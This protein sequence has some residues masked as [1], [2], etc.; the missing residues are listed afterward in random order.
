MINNVSR[1]SK[2]SHATILDLSCMRRTMVD[3]RGK[4][5]VKNRKAGFCGCCVIYT[6][7]RSSMASN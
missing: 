7:A 2:L 6:S 1:Y 4:K 3:E 5:K